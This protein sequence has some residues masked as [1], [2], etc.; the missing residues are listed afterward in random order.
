MDGK[1]AIVIAHTYA[2]ISQSISINR[3]RFACTAVI[4]FCA[5]NYVTV[6]AG[7]QTC[8]EFHV[9]VASVTVECNETVV[10]A[11]EGNLV[12][13]IIPPIR[14]ICATYCISEDDHIVNLT[15]TVLAYP[16]V[17]AGAIRIELW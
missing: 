2:D 4:R 17:V 8:L 5:R 1:Y 14:Y 10:A 7:R 3:N 6:E 15:P 12:V 16:A 13:T 9:Q 11:T